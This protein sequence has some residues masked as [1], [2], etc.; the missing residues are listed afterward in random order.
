M[1]KL[2]WEKK[3]L[4][5]LLGWEYNCKCQNKGSKRV[6]ETWMCFFRDLWDCGGGEE[7]GSLG[8]CVC[9]SLR[10][11]GSGGGAIRKCKPHLTL[12]HIENRV[13]FPVVAEKG[14]EGI[15]DWRGM[16]TWWYML[17]GCVERVDK[18]LYWNVVCWKVV[19]CNSEM[20]CVVEFVRSFDHVFIC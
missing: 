11:C 12:F 8:R 20:G 9:V 16:R 1:L 19:C 2:D 10:A 15:I 14:N 4:T 3:C 5:D 18:R 7:R 6:W 13:I 17:I